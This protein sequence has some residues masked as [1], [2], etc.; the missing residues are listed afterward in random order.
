MNH[1]LFCLAGFG[2]IFLIVLVIVEF[3]YLKFSFPVEFS[4]KA[5]HIIAGT[6]ASFFIFIF[7]KQVTAIIMA[8]FF[9]FISWLSK[10]TGMLKSMHSVHRESIGE[11]IFPL[12]ICL[13]FVLTRMTEIPGYSYFCAVMVLSIADPM[14]SFGGLINL[15][16]NGNKKWVI[17]NKPNKIKTWP[18]TAFFFISTLLITFLTFKYFLSLPY[19]VIFISAVLI[20]LIAAISELLSYNGW[21]NLTA[22]LS[23][24]FSIYVSEVIFT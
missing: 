3:L 23:V 17:T 13:I 24:W 12:S 5:I 11:Y 8:V 22:P 20:S 14:A 7:E 9:F 16:M 1:D 18:G 21:D 15:R 2:F 19:P 4:R 10:K 6:I